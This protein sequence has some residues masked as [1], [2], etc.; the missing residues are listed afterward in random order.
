MPIVRQVFR[1]SGRRSLL[2]FTLVSSAA[3]YSTGWFALSHAV[4]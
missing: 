3:M 4:W 2:P 1:Y